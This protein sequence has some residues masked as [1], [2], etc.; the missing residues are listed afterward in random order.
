[1]LLSD[2]VVGRL[3]RHTLKASFFRRSSADT[4]ADGSCSSGS[5]PGANVFCIPSRIFCCTRCTL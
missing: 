3:Q 5:S 1:V 2:G 4:P